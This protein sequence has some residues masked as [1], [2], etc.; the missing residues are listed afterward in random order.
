M[1]ASGYMASCWDPY[2]ASLA[3]NIQL[4]SVYPPIPVSCTDPFSLHGKRYLSQ[5]ILMKVAGAG[6]TVPVLSSM[7]ISSVF[8]LLV[9][10]LFMID[11]PRGRASGC[12][13]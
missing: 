6:K 2:N 5:L 11:G 9:G 13:D 7:I 8:L 1:Y 12:L 3:I 4:I 10:T